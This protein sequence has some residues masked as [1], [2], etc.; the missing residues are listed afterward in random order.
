MMLIERYI[1]KAILSAIG[2]V[3]LLLV[4]LQLFMLS[5]NEL[6][7]IGRGDFN[8]LQ[9]M[10]YVF[11]QMPY[12]VYLFFPLASLLGALIGLG[13]MANHHELIIM[14]AAGMSILQITFAILKVAFILV[15]AVTIIGETI[16]PPLAHF[17][18]DQRMQAISQ[19]QTIRTAQGIWVRHKNDFISIGAVLP[20]N[21]LENVYQIHFDDHH[22]LQF[23]RQIE[24]IIFIKGKWIA[25]NIAETTISRAQTI[26]KT[27][28]KLNWNVNLKPFIL[29][30]NSNDPD[31]MTL[32]ALRR[33]LH[34]QKKN[35]QTVLNYQLVYWQRIIQPLTTMVMIIL[36][37]PF[38]FGPLRTSTMGSKLLTGAI[39]GFSFH[40]M[41]RFFGPLSQVLQW[42]PI[43]TA[44]GPTILFGFLG[45]YLMRRLG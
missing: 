23:T 38:I 33:Y 37:V 25:Y 5:V 4:G 9:A 41:N 13:I 17:A 29:S 8:L 28:S 34:A 45:I 35:H 39:I 7:E 10:L 27:I 11:L 18:S 1:A 24:K 15:I 16:V 30:V 42:S 19:G 26:I 6:S 20:T 32:Q 31:E 2:L 44:L 12:Q 22:N 3:T 43:F 21:T 40:I 14:R 36:A